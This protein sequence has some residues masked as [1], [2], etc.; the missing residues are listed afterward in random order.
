[1]PVAVIVMVVAMMIVVGMLFLTE[2]PAIIVVEIA[3]SVVIPV[4]IVFDASTR[5]VPVALIESS[6]FVAR[7]DPVSSFVRRFSPIA[8]V[9]CVA[10]GNGIPVAIHPHVD[11]LWPRRSDH[12]NAGRR[13]RPNRDSYGNLRANAGNRCT[14]HCNK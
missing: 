10:P 9:P 13:W 5:T 12:H 3:V 6:M 8:R 4:V 11:R 1:M 14:Q 2:V 7:R